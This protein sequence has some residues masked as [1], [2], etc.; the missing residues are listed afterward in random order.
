MGMKIKYVEND[1]FM[2]HNSGIRPKIE[3]VNY[4]K[5]LY[6]HLA[7]SGHRCIFS[8]AT[9]LTVF[10]IENTKKLPPTLTFDGD[11]LRKK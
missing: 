7:N 10:F 3:K 11:H 6:S 2:S 9:V 4:T 1:P 8:G 5:F